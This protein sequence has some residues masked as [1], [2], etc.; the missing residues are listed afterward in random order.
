VLNEH[1]VQNSRTRHRV[2]DLGEVVDLLWEGDE[3]WILHCDV[4]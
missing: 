2:R 1:D 4:H 3:L